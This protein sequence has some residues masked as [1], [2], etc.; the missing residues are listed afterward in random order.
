MH[1]APS[2]P[3]LALL[4]ASEE[5]TFLP[6]CSEKTVGKEIKKKKKNSMG[7]PQLPR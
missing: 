2:T 1:D 3:Y 4:E 6:N 7:A 5:S